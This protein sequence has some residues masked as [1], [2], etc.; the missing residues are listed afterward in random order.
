MKINSDLVR[1]LR[2]A[3]NWSQEQLS[4][5]CGLSLR[6]IQRMENGGSASLESIRILSNFFEI[7]P[8]KL[9]L[10]EEEEPMTPRDAVETGLRQY[11][12]FSGTATRYE[13]GWFLLFVVLVLAIASVVH[14]S[15]NQIASLILIVP[16]LAAGTRRLNSLGHSGWWQ[17]LWFVPFGQLIVLWLMFQEDEAPPIQ[18]L[19]SKPEAA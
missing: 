18:P 17:F 7:D 9:I 14:E 11:A 19:K 10:N 3:G 5:A 6:T 15:A 8:N 4:E 16:L 13:Y 2:I 1:K 12:D